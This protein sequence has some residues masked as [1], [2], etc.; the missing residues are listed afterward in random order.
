MEPVH[1]EAP[2]NL[3]ISFSAIHTWVYMF[4][5]SKFKFQ[6][7]SLAL[8]LGPAHG[9]VVWSLSFFHVHLTRSSELFLVLKNQNGV[10]RSVQDMVESNGRPLKSSRLK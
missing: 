6:K 3:F 5:S 9:A 4:S 8:D 10:H 7:M 2:L 1:P